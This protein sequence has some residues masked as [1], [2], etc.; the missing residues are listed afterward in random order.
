MTDGEQ[1]Q[2]LR[3]GG[4][5]GDRRRSSSRHRRSKLDNEAPSAGYHSEGRQ[6][7]GHRGQSQGREE[8][9]GQ[10]IKNKIE[11]TPDFFENLRY[12]ITSYLREFI[13]NNPL[14]WVILIVLLNVNIKCLTPNI[15][16]HFKCK[17][18]VDTNVLGK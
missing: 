12:L 1:H 10:T 14:K 17:R 6:G 13:L 5:A 15:K 7:P 9:T 16:P 4:G 2:S 3:K 8:T 11:P 18:D